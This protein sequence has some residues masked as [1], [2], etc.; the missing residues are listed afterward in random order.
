[1][2]VPAA[3]FAHIHQTLFNIETIEPGYFSQDV[4]SGFKSRP[5]AAHDR[6][7]FFP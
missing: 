7:Q 2:F 1:M 3:L 6:R 4:R 5:Q